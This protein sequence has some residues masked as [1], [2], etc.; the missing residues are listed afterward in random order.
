ML[1]VVFIF[2][3]TAISPSL[4]LK[5]HV[6]DPTALYDIVTNVMLLLR[7]GALGS[8]DPVHSPIFLCFLG[9]YRAALCPRIHSK[10]G[11]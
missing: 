5:K 2:P 11:L 3:S 1:I 4:S 7:N 9:V 6:P 10:D 8:T